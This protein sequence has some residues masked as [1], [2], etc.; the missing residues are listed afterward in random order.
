MKQL[1]AWIT[2]ERCVLRTKHVEHKLVGGNVS[3]PESYRIKDT[4]VGHCHF[5]LSDMQQYDLDVEE[6]KDGKWVPFKLPKGDKI[7]VALTMLDPWV[8]QDLVMTAPGHY[9]AQFRVPDQHGVFTMSVEYKRYGWTYLS[10]KHKVSA[11]PFR[12]DAYPR[13]LSAAYP[14]YAVMGSMIVAW[15]VFSVVYLFAGEPKG[16]AKQQ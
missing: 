2:Q 12:H 8:R 14:Y 9:S 11:L 5:D 6:K 15:I 7:Q 3:M 10:V 13:F 1:L 16:K 4:V